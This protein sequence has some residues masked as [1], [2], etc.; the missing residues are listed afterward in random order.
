MRIRI[1]HVSLPANHGL[2]RGLE[3]EARE[4]DHVNG[5]GRPYVEVLA[6]R[7]QVWCRIWPHEYEVIEE[8]DDAGQAD[9]SVD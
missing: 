2:A 4:T 3:L 5:F 6:P 7:T 1:K 8:E 9:V